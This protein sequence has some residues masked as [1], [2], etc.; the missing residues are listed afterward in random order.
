[1]KLKGFEQQRAGRLLVAAVSP[2]AMMA[3]MAAMNSGTSLVTNEFAPVVTWLRDLLA[4]DYTMV[5]ALIVLVA[6]IWQLAHGG[7]YKTVAVILGVLAIALV[8]PG[9]LTTASTSMPSFEQMKLVAY[10]DQ[11]PVSTS[12]TLLAMP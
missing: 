12:V 3:C 6:G 5:M 8:G 11:G 1:M 9:V 4:S 10:V 7:G 2:V